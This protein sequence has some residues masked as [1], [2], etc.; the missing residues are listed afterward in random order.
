[1]EKSRT[2]CL[3]SPHS[4]VVH[5]DLESDLQ[6]A[7]VPRNGS[8]EPL[9]PQKARDALNPPAPRKGPGCLKGRAQVPWC[10]PLRGQLTGG[11]NPDPVDVGQL[12][13]WALLDDDVPACLQMEVA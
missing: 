10:P 9:M 2:A 12:P 5:S 1:M 11:C 6:D 3:K 4:L 13:P 8:K 7:S